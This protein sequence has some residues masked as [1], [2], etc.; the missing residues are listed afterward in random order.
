MEVYGRTGSVQTVG[1]DGLGVR[2]EGKPEESPQGTAAPPPRRTTSSRYFA[3]VVRGEV[4]PAGLS[5]LPKPHRHRDP[6]RRPPVRRRDRQG[7]GACPII[8]RDGAIFPRATTGLRLPRRMGS[9]P[10]E[11]SGWPSD[12]G[13]RE[14][15]TLAMSAARSRAES[16]AAAFGLPIRDSPPPS[17]HQGGGMI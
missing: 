14:R 9:K 5:S 4:R 15:G 12:T 7:G 17:P 13:R 10:Q 16:D 6:R 11:S 2:L 8:R 1:P 3:A